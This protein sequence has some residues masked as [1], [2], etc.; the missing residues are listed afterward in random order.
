MSL[1]TDK[2]LDNGMQSGVADWVISLR[3]TSDLNRSMFQGVIEAQHA[4]SI[5]V[6][7]QAMA[8][9]LASICPHDPELVCDEC[10]VCHD[11]DVALLREGKAPWEEDY[12]VHTTRKT[13]R[14]ISPD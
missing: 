4:K 12:A 3:P 5:K 8:E 1:L 2:E 14:T 13:P 10:A 11:N 9:W 6:D 7:R